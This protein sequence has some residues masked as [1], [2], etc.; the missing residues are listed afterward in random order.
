M[1][2]DANEGELKIADADFLGDHASTWIAR[3]AHEFSVLNVHAREIRAPAARIF[4][5]LGD[6][7]LLAPNWYYRVLFAV[8]AAAGGI[9]GWDRGLAWHGSEPL[10]VGKHFAFFLIEYVDAPRELSMSVNNRLT[11]ALMGWVLEE[12][13]GTTKVVNATCANFPGWRGRLYWRVIQPFH[14]A[15]IEDSLKALSRRMQRPAE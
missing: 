14:D 15:L 5:E 2:G 11:G 9:F 6:Q 3:Q 8:R 4:P 13:A 1:C 10:E 7:K 12:S